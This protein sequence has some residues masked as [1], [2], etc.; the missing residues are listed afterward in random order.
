MLIQLSSENGLPLYQQVYVAIR[1]A[2]TRQHI[3]QG[4]R[5]PAS[6]ELAKQ[7]S[8]S[9]NTINN[10]YT[11]LCAEGFLES[12]QGSGY[13]VAEHIAHT[14]PPNTQSTQQKTPA[15]GFSKRGAYLVRPTRPVPTS[16]NP[17][18]Q[19][20]LPD[21]EQ[22]PF[23]QWRQCLNRIQQSR[24]P[25]LLKYSDQ[26]GYYPLKQAL[27]QYLQQARGVNCAAEQIIIVNGSQAGLDLVSRLLLDT[28]DTVA[29]EDPGY[30]G[31]RDAFLAASAKLIP[32]PV[33]GEGLNTDILERKRRAIKLVYTTPS[34]Q[35]PMGTTLSLTRRLHL[36]QWANKN[37]AFIL[38]DDYDSEFRYRERP[39]S[40]LQGLDESGRVIYMGTLSK[41][42][43]PALRLG[44]LVVPPNMA[45]GFA[46]ALRKTGQD[47][48]LQLQAALS[49][50]IEN[51]FFETH[52]RRMRKSYSE[53][54]QKLVACCQKHLGDMLEVK[55]TSA[56]MQLPALFKKPINENT[57]LS[58]SQSADI[59]LST[60][61]RYCLSE[62]KLAGVYLGYAGIPLD[63]IENNILR[64]KEILVQAIDT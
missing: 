24:E 27:Q 30:L 35:F 16:K 38:E 11:Q 46:K 43:F 54:Q 3:A 49:L 37:D 7:L 56:G 44:Y 53:K 22:F 45:E 9:R 62:E 40:S 23:S 12:V 26:G 60:L 31:A 36:L 28:N 2:I 6:R 41:V 4:Y 50:F 21:L 39:L 42:L 34:Y 63:D 15:F 17:A 25:E 58:L 5:M 51:G 19:P 20:G 18:F 47:A 10:A 59:V 32:I 29:M 14:V 8:V 55:I 64:L 33:D 61:S 48:P 1:Q 52:I 57:L 13:F